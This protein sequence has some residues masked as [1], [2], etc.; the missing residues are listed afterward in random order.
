[1]PLSN[2]DGVLMSSNPSEKRMTG[3]DATIENMAVTWH[4]R[5]GHINYAALKKIRHTKKISGWK[6]TDEEFKRA[7]TKLCPGCTAGKYRER[8]THS[9]SQGPSIKLVRCLQRVKMDIICLPNNPDRNDN[10][11]ALLLI[12]L[13]SGRIW[14]YLMARRSEALKY[15]EK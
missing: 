11:Y 6:F 3:K 12:D 2:L 15:V 13:F 14:I 7:T 1:M 10:K 8:P 4:N 9:K 5:L